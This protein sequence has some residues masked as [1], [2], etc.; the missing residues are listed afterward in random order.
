MSFLAVKLRLDRQNL[1]YERST[2]FPDDLY[3]ECLRQRL[4]FEEWHNWVEWT[5]RQL[6]REKTKDISNF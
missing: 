4:P 3:Q 5:L 6:S 1:T 2:P